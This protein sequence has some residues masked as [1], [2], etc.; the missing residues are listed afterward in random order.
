MVGPGAGTSC[1]SPSGGAQRE[2]SPG[3]GAQC[4]ALRLGVGRRADRLRGPSP[5]CLGITGAAA[6]CEAHGEATS[7]PPRNR[8]QHG[9]GALPCTAFL[10]RSV[11][12]RCIPS[13]WPTTV[14]AYVPCSRAKRRRARSAR[15]SQQD[16]AGVEG[17]TPM[18][19]A[20]EVFHGDPGP[21]PRSATPPRVR[22]RRAPQPAR[23]AR[24]RVGGSCEDQV[25]TVDCSLLGC[26]FLTPCTRRG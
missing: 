4:F 16:A 1:S 8:V 10:G 14:G 13:R 23:R 3:V 24:A 6:L 12:A 25:R 9:M 19:P 17:T 26:G 7:D 21:H 22:C 15:V 11:V 5:A 2:R 20:R 18:N